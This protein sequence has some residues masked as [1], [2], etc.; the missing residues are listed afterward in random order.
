[1]SYFLFGARGTGKTTFLR[2]EVIKENYVY[3]NLLL[4]KEFNNYRK[5]PDLLTEVVELNKGISPWVIIDEVQKV[6]A[7][8]DVV[9]HLIESSNIKFILTGSSAR[10]LKHDSANLLAGRAFINN[11]YPLTFR[12]LENS[13]L[14]STKLEKKNYLHQVLTWGS[15]PKIINL[16]EKDD[17]ISYLYSYASTY[18]KEEILQEQIIRN[19][20]PFARFLEV[21]AQMNGEI[22]NYSKIAR[23]SGTSPN[24]VQS[25]FQILEDTLLGFILQPYHQSIRKQQRAN[26]KFYFFDSGIAR[27]LSNTISIELPKSGY[28]FGKLFE[29]FIINECLRLNSYLRKQ[30]KFFFLRTKSNAEI[31]LIIERPGMPLALIEIKAS[32]NV[33]EYDLKNLISLGKDLKNSELFCFSQDENNRIINGVKCLHWEKGLEEIGL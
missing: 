28:G 9:H 19:L 4:A 27:T 6:P 11:L 10:K 21:A 31:D 33:S 7:L 30:Y 2:E 18:L 12:E 24:S 32:D 20:D 15:L 13:K 8:L 22:I 23:E 1:M 26:P 29:S 5:N 16:S 3:I 25:Y 17:K 14:F